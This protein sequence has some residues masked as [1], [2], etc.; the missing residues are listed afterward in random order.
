[1]DDDIERMLLP[2]QILIDLTELGSA[3][4]LG[5]ILAVIAERLAQVRAGEQMA[6]TGTDL[7]GAVES[8]TVAGDYARA[9]A[10]L[11]AGIDRD[12]LR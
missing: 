9:A 5:G 2:Q 8:D 12:G 3:G 6:L 10:L 1:M 4:A 7:V 11:A